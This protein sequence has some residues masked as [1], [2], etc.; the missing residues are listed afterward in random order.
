MNIVMAT[1]LINIF[2]TFSLLTLD[3]VNE[4]NQQL[5]VNIPE[6]DNTNN[7]DISEAN[8]QPPSYQEAINSQ[9]NPTDETK[10]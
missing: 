1:F 10:K 7:S 3:N 2:K 6:E 8:P 5:H 4:T 9:D